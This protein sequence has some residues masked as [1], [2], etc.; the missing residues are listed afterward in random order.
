MLADDVKLDLVARLKR[1]GR[2]MIDQYFTRY[3]QA[4]HWRFAAGSV[5]RAPAML[6][7]DA[8]GPLAKPAHFVILDWQSGRISGIATSCSRRP[9]LRRLDGFGFTRVVRSTSKSCLILRAPPGGDNRIC[10]YPSR[11][12]TIGVLTIDRPNQVWAADITYIAAGPRLP[13]GGYAIRMK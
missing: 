3:A 4:R 2:E 6:V 10:P 13:D 12:M 1:Q 5:D 11:V 8:N 9:P 7:F